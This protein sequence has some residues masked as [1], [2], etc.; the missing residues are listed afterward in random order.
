MQVGSSFAGRYRIEAARSDTATPAFFGKS[1]VTGESVQV[2]Q[3]SGTLFRVLSRAQDYSHSRFCSVI[4]TISRAGEPGWV[5]TQHVPSK[6]LEQALTNSSI[7]PAEISV[8][9][10]IDL[11]DAL[12]GLHQRGVVHGLIHPASVLVV[13]ADYSESKLGY[14][15]PAPSPNPYLPPEHNPSEPSAADDVWALAGVLHRILTGQ[16]PPRSG[17]PSR[18]L[19]PRGSIPPDLIDVLASCLAQDAGGRVSAAHSFRDLLA[20]SRANSL[21]PGAV[22]AQPPPIRVAMPPPLDA[23]AKDL[24]STGVQPPPSIP[25][26]PGRV[27]HIKVPKPVP[28]PTHSV[29]PRWLI[30]AILVAVVVT[31]VSVVAILVFGGVIG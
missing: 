17:Y 31:V 1:T 14:A 16:P 6:T 3:L 8:M 9:I 11:S 13:G 7:L 12:V 24:S 20:C 21:R 22:S 26:R 27:E 10:G 28:P 19:V 4:E 29:D 5:I 18:E 15:P 30:Q 25:L 23:I 2:F